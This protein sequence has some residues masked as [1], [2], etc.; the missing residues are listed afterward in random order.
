VAVTGARVS[1]AGSAATKAAASS[2]NAGESS[3]STMISGV[4][5]RVH[6]AAVAARGSTA[7]RP[8]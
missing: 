4:H 8:S 6:A 7:R 1:I 5:Q 3:S 2:V